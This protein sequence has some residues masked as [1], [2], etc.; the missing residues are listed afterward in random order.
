ML[1]ASRFVPQEG[2]FGTAQNVFGKPFGTACMPFPYKW[3][4]AAQPK[5]TCIIR[6]YI[7]FKAFLTIQKY[8]SRLISLLP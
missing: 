5:K 4:F 8:F 6:N 7:I 3:H 1:S 2:L